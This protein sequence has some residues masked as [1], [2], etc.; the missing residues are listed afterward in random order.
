MQQPIRVVSKVNP[1]LY[2]DAIPGHF[3]TNHS[4]INYYIDMSAIK[5]SQS[6]ATEAA[7]SIA[8]H[9]SSVNIDTILC[10]EGTEYIGAFLARELSRDGFRSMNGGSDLFLVEPDSN[11]N[12]QFIFSDNL[13][14]MIFSKNVLVLVT[15]ASTGQTLSQARECV[16]YYGGRIA[17]YSA[18]FSNIKDLNGKQV[19]SLFSGLDFPH[20]HNCSHGKNCPDCAAGVPLDAIVT[21]RGYTKL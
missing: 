19:V 15:S 20:Y 21:P 17:G 10:L 6:M 1:K 5:H 2:A 9:F 8:Y 3:A 16:E 12:G 7:A 13:T 4:H 18:L 11:V 14:P